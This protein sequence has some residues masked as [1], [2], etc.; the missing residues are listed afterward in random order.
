MFDFV[1]T[2]GFVGNQLFIDLV[3]GEILRNL[4]ITSSGGLLGCQF[5]ETNWVQRIFFL[6]K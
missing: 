5:S 1:K 6:F 4:F 3:P 2:G